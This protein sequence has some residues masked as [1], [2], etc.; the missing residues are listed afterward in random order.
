MAVADPVALFDLDNTLV[1]RVAAFR[2]WA[3]GFTSEHGLDHSAVEWLCEQDDDGFAARDELLAAARTRFSITEPVARLLRRYRRDYPR[4]YVPDP[5]VHAALASLR[6]AGWRVGIVTNGP[7]SQ[8]EKI[9][10]CG[11]RPLV[12][13]WA[14]S[15][16]IGV[17]K[18]DPRIFAE[19]VRRCGVGSRSPVWMTGDTAAADIDGGRRSGCRTIWLRRGRSWELADFAPDVIV[20]SVADA[21][22]AMLAGGHDARHGQPAGANGDAGPEAGRPAQSPGPNN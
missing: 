14:I 4:H 19:A 20:D 6:R 5:R 8:A 7:P 10:R 3:E 21:V 12:D 18:P 11:L 13:A 16:E 17:A 9:D 15:G 2:R 22:H 1:D